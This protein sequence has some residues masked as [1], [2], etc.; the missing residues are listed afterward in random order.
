MLRQVQHE[1]RTLN[2][3]NMRSV[4]PEPVEGREK[5]FSASRLT[6]NVPD[7]PLENLDVD[8]LRLGFFCL[9]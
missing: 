6:N 1:R 4:G 9:R 2:D 5:G 3:F 7:P 8:P